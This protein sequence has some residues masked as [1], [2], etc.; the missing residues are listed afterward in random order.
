MHPTKAPEPDSF[1]AIFYQKFW[2]NCRP[3]C[4]S[5]VLDSFNGNGDLGEVNETFLVL[6]SKVK[7]PKK[8]YEFRPINH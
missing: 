8:I 4:D 7:G 1:H 2:S 5:M 6:I 3:G